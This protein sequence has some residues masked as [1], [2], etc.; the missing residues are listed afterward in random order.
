MGTPDPDDWPEV[1]SMPCYLPFE[2]QKAKD[3][4]T[5]LAARKLASRGDGDVNPAIIRI[6]AQMLQL[7]P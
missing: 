1:E 3:L 5:V 4:K 6:V 2:A 7:N